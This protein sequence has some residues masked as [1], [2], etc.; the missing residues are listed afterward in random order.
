MI[1]AMWEKAD[2]CLKK[3]GYV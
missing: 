2:Q 1:D 3:G